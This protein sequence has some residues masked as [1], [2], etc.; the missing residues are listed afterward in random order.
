MLS[1]CGCQQLQCACDCEEDITNCSD[2]RCAA[3]S[4]EAVQCLEV[5][6]VGGR[7]DEDKEGRKSRRVSACTLLSRAGGR[8]ISDMRV[9]TRSDGSAL[10]QCR[11]RVLLL[12]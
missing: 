7:K 9:C 10:L 8:R 4:H 2:G 3:S 1:A 11:Y 5:F 12:L 6:H